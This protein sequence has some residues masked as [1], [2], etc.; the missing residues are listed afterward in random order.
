MTAIASRAIVE[1]INLIQKQMVRQRIEELENAAH[2]DA[3]SAR[4]A[5][6]E[7]V[8]LTA[9]LERL[10]VEERVGQARTLA[11]VVHDMRVKNAKLE[12]RA[13]RAEEPLMMGLATG[14]PGRRTR[15]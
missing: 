14:L 9:I 8:E 15:A 3:D 5:I 10:G 13:R 11:S 6:K 1:Q 7:G 12:K 4:A 2:K